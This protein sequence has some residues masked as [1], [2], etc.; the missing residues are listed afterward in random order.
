M[1]RMQMSTQEEHNNGRDHKAG[2]ENVIFLF[3]ERSKCWRF[4]HSETL[5]KTVCPT[6]DTHWHP[7]HPLFRLQRL[8]KQNKTFFFAENGK[9]MHFYVRSNSGD[10]LS[11]FCILADVFR[12]QISTAG[13]MN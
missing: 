3:C 8:K 5:A 11:V 2:S 10:V 9:L 7:A 1:N 13:A 6:K 12:S 4:F